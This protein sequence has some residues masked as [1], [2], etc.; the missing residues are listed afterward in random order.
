[1]S[2]YEQDDIAEADYEAI[3]SKSVRY[4]FA[5]TGDPHDFAIA[6]SHRPNILTRTIQRLI[7]GFRYY[8]IPG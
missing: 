2:I 5:P 1:M 8:Q 7:L 3:K 6:V 4:I